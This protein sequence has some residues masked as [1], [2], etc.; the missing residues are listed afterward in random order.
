MS[1]NPKLSPLPNSKTGLKKGDWVSHKSA[2]GCAIRC[3]HRVDPQGDITFVDEV[4]GT[5]NEGQVEKIED[6]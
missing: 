2:D 5:I 3:V 1:L 4:E 6:G